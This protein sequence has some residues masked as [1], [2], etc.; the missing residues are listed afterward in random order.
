MKRITFTVIIVFCSLISFCPAQGNNIK[1]DLNSDKLFDYQK[2]TLDNGMDVITLEDFSCPIVAVQVW[3]H[4]GSK[5]E[6]SDRQGY[7][8]MFE[9]MMFKG[10][11]VVSEQDHFNLLRKVGGTCNAYTSFDQTVYH[12]IVPSEEVE[13]AL[14]LEAE[15]M[16]FLKIDQRAFDTERKVVEEELRMGENRPYGNVSKKLFAAFFDEHPYRWTPIGK[17][18]D[19]RATSVQDLRQFWFKYYIPNNATL[20]VVGDIKHEKAQALARKYFGWIPS[21]PQPPRVTVKEPAQ[22]KPKTVI[23]DDENAPAGQVLLGWRTVPVGT[24]EETVLDCLSQILG[25]GHSSRL[26]R[27][28]VADTQIAVDASSTTYNLEQA[29]IFMAEATLPPTSGDYDGVI[30]ALTEQIKKIQNEGITDE[31]L[32]KARNQMLKSMVTTNL[33]IESKA[34][35]L[36]S[37]AVTIGDISKVNTKMDEIRS[38]TKADIVR[39]AK[40]YLDWE[41]VLTFTIKQNVGMQNTLKDDETSEITA[42]PELEAPTP[43]RPGVKR[44]ADFPNKPPIVTMA[45]SSF[46]LDYGRDK[47]DNGLKVIVVPNHEVPFVSVMLGLTNGAWTDTTAGTAAMTLSMLTRGTQKYSEA[48]LAEELERYAISL[49]GSA[50]MDTAT[51]GMNCTTEQ[52]DRGMGLLAE[53][54]LQPTFPQV[55]FDKLLQQKLTDLN[56]NQQDPRYLVNLYLDKIIFGEHPYARPTEGTPDSIQHLKPADLELWWDKFARPDQASIIFAGDIT[57]DRAMALAKEY[58]GDWKTDLVE[59][60][61]V[62]PDIPEP[63]PTTL[64]LINR[65]GS[66]QAEIRVGQL[67]ITRRQQPDYFISLLAGA[68]FGGSFHSRLNENIRVKRGLTYGAFGG[69]RANNMAGTFEVSTFTKNESTDETI[70]VILDQINEF[71]TIEPTDSEF[72]DTRNYFIGS[73]PSQRETPQDV[74]R[75][76]W[77]IESQRLGSDYFK[78]MFETLDEATKQ[79]CLDLTQKTLAPDKLAIVVVGDAEALK[80]PLSEIAPVEVI[81]PE[82]QQLSLVH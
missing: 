69:F 11:D 40:E 43:G 4:V 2:I 70:Q 25:S 57:Q 29:G 78:K 75:D 31:E 13:L 17:L 15:R 56:I 21:G 19:L 7:A 71:Q 41:K 48:E 79:D 28:L 66:A 23:V 37:A 35:M 39:A 67:G 10:T 52:L 82:Q 61:I 24:R 22:S 77:L 51:V 45:K 58:L 42:E 46:D 20:I 14:W 3:Y 12:E 16:G 81:E 18:A 33:S 63:K 44:P 30:N 36:G 32:E 80:E 73:F 64:Y 38:V 55:E 53:V 49:N 1:P 74:A 62:L 27:T 26:Y 60:G 34:R 54:V 65:P 76:L 9:H 72:Y 6:K 68:Y 50:D 8:H 59:A 5:N 47:L